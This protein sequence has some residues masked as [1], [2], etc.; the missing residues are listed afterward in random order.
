MAIQ[1][2]GVLAAAQAEYR[3]AAVVFG[4]LDQLV[5]WLTNVSSPAER[6]EYEQALASA[7]AALG[8]EAF[9]AAWA[10]GQATTLEQMEALAL[11]VG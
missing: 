5:G 9:T 3:R 2:L 4:A 1:A 7:R 11:E 10:E 8:E 6:D